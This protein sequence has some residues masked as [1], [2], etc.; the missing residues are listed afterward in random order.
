[1]ARMTSHVTSERPVLCCI[2]DEQTRPPT[3]VGGR[4]ASPLTNF[5]AQAGNACKF[6]PLSEVRVRSRVIACAAMM[7]S[8]PPIGVPANSS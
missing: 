6:P 8:L 3:V 4:P 7:R 1:M 5:D 2:T